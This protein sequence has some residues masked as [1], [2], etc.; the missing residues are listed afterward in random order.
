[1]N[2]L[3]KRNNTMKT[4]ERM[5]LD[6]ASHG[7]PIKFGQKLIPPF[8]LE[9]FDSRN[10][11]F[12]GTSDFDTMSESTMCMAAKANSVPFKAILHDSSGHWVEYVNGVIESWSVS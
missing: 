9:V 6:K 2:H 11:S 1:M 7:N 3:T 12:D 4:T 10:T 8:T 5:L